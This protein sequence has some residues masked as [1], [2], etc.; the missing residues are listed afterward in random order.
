MTLVLTWAHLEA[1]ATVALALGTFVGWLL[2]RIDKGHKEQ[3]EALE[4]KLGLKNAE[5]D[6]EIKKLS[7]NLEKAWHAVH[8]VEKDVQAQSLY[9]A[10]TFVTKL[11][12]SVTEANILKRLE[13][14][15]EKLTMLLARHGSAD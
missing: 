11:D 4:E 12:H 6:R 1:A 15:D 8:Q 14:V 13:A 9:N 7:E 2:H 10:Q 5:Q 3:R